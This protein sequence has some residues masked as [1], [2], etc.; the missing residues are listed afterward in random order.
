[1]GIINFGDDHFAFLQFVKCKICSPWIPRP[2]N[3]KVHNVNQVTAHC[4][5]KGIADDLGNFYIFTNITYSDSGENAVDSRIAHGWPG[6]DQHMDDVGN[7]AEHT[8]TDTDVA[9]DWGVQSKQ[10]T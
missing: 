6:E 9:M 3:H 5:Q 7:D 10:L 1:M 4:S 2:L 8:Q